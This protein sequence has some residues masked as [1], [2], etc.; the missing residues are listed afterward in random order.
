MIMAGGT[1][2]HVFPGLAV[3]DFLRESGWRVVWL[4]ARSGI[5]ATLVPSR[6]YDMAWVNF[7]GLRGKGPIVF[8]LLPARLLLAFRQSAR[9]IFAQRPLSLIHI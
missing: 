1:G 5:E 7:S 2:G 4:G 8:L 6:G 9:A 3:A